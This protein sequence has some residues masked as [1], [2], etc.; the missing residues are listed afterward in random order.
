MKASAEP[1]CREPDGAGD[2]TMDCRLFP[3]K[4]DF[5]PA[6]E[7][8]GAL[9]GDETALRLKADVSGFEDLGDHAAVRTL[10]CF[11][12]DA[13]RLAV[14]AELE[15]LEALYIEDLRV[16]DLSPLSALT[17]L[18]VLGVDGAAKVESLDWLGRLCPLSEL[19][20][21]HFPR[22]HSLEPL[23]GQRG[24]EA[25][26]VSGSTWTRM[27]VQ[28]FTP[29]SQL[30]ELRTLYLTNTQCLDGSLRALATLQRL[31]ELHI[32]GFYDW[33]EFAMLSGLRP[34]IE[35]SWFRP[36]LELDHQRCDVC[37]S[38]LVMLTG[39][40]QP[41]LCPSCQADRVERHVARF[42]RAADEAARKADAPD[43]DSRRE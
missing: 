16:D 27:K 30:R 41:T 28:S 2:R 34:D 26:D 14:L 35:C 21:Q 3:A 10:W 1:P 36:Y 8:I 15:G 37:G 43:R 20:L 40:G 13:G 38:S 39:K 32:A 4:I 23:T 24:L 9:S 22:V 18:D 12:I 31:R 17:R 29:L 25:L 5:P 7:D 6:V 42:Q 11:R 33:R 19:R